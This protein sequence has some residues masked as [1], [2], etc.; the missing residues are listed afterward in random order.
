[1][2][3]YI[4]AP[5][6]LTQCA[7]TG[8]IKEVAQRNTLNKYFVALH[9]IPSPNELYVMADQYTIAEERKKKRLKTILY[10]LLGLGLFK[11][12]AMVYD[13]RE[14]FLEGFWKSVC[15]VLNCG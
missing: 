14:S 1:M 5:A 11:I 9:S 10:I 13:N 3:G 2:L 4:D 15:A 7:I 6:D 12:F 8:S